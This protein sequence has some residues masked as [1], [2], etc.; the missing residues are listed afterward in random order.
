MS[1]VISTVAALVVCTA[2]VNVQP[3]HSKSTALLSRGRSTDKGTPQAS[4]HVN[5]TAF[6]NLWSRPPSCIQNTGVSCLAKGCDASQGDTE[7]KFAQCFCKAGCSDGNG[8]CH[9]S[10]NVLVATGIRLKNSRWPQYYLVASTMDNEIHVANNGADPLAQFNLYQL[11]GQGKQPEG[12]LLVPQTS[13]GYSVSIVHKYLCNDLMARDARDHK[14]E[15]HDQETNMTGASCKHSWTAQTQAL[16]PTYTSH[17][18]VQDA[19][20]Q[21]SNAPVDTKNG[22]AMTIRGIGE[23]VSKYMFVHEGS[24]KVSSRPDDPGPGGYWIPEPAL[25][26]QLPDYHGPPCKIACERS[27]SMRNAIVGGWSLIVLTVAVLQL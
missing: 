4:D 14:E 6:A 15:E 9:T 13:P 10:Q 23:H 18:S 22:V 8:G 1:L 7:C 16:S 17:P 21:L 3:R 27:M 24:W 19:A 20:V 5:D 2:S 25:A 12:F 11:P 26:F